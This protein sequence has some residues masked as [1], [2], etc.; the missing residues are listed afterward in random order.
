MKT[1][2]GI[3]V[4][5]QS[6]KVLCYNPDK[7]Q[8]EAAADSDLELRQDETGTAEQDAQWW[9][10][11]LAQCLEKIPSNVKDSVVSISVSGQQHGFVALNREGKVIAPVKLWCD[12]TTVQECEDIM[13]RM[14]GR[15]RCIE[16]L[17]NAILTGYT[18]PKIL[19]LKKNK[20][21]LYAELDTILL[22]HDYINYHLSGKAVMEYG[23]AS[24]TGLLNVY[25]REWDSEILQA[26][27]PDKNLAACLPSFE[28]PGKLSKKAAAHYGLKSGIVIAA[29]GGD[30]MMAAIGTGNVKEG[31]VTISLGSS[32]TVYAYS[33]QPIVDQQERL[34]AFCSSTGGWL[35]LLCTM[36]CTMSTELMRNVLS[37]DLEELDNAID[38]S[39]IGANG[40]LALPF[41]NG[42][43]SPNLPNA[44]ASFFGLD[45]I[46]STSSN[47]LRATMEGVTFSLRLGL[48]ALKENGL[49]ISEIRLTGGGSHSNVWRQIVADICQV[50]VIPLQQDEGAAFGAALQAYSEYSKQTITDIVQ[51]YVML[52]QTAR[53]NPI[54]ENQ[55]MYNTVFQQYKKAVQLIENYY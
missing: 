12:T 5:T 40:I 43:R 33:D 20:P 6:V 51:Q 38:S 11:A 26:I 2:M 44:K 25:T 4:G 24:G 54:K 55:E 10:N 16:K 7:R 22:P 42:E 50:S 32:G 15:E 13:S 9:L 19:W 1:V 35:P 37:T 18:A 52:D 29:G 30:N 45:S 23:D 36:N 49:Q 28:S 21:N 34:A 53:C 14:G 41:F 17:G 48:D 27:D 46:N 3:D 47:L 39:P 31:V 8:I